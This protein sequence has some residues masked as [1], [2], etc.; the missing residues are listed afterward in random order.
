LAAIRLIAHGPLKLRLLLA[1]LAPWQQFSRAHSF[2]GLRP[3]PHDLRRI[4][5]GSSAVVSCLA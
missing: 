2:L 3:Q 4:A 5:G 1:S